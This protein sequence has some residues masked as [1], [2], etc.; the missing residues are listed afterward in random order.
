M[1]TK[2]MK[3]LSEQKLCVLPLIQKQI[4]P[5]T[6]TLMVSTPQ[7]IRA[8]SFSRECQNCHL[9]GQVLRHVYLPVSDP[10]FR[11][12]EA[13]QLDRTLNALF[14]LLVLEEKTYG[15]YCAAISMCC[16]QVVRFLSRPKYKQLLINFA[17]HFSHCMTHQCSASKTNSR[18]AGS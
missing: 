5:D 3:L 17:A 8:A 9:I 13:L 7:D 6:N 15:M 11:E 10:E 14:P 16:R 2:C 1:G 12:T 18:R 4:I